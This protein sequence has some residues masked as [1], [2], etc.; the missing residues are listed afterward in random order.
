[1]HTSPSAPL[2]WSLRGLSEVAPPPPPAAQN[3]V[4]SGDRRSTTT[5]PTTLLCMRSVHFNHAM[6]REKHTKS[7]RCLVAAPRRVAESLK[8]QKIR[9]S[10]SGARAPRTPPHD[11]RPT[12]RRVRRIWRHSAEPLFRVSLSWPRGRSRAAE[13]SKISRGFPTSAAR[14]KRTTRCREAVSST[15]VRPASSPQ[16]SQPRPCLLV[17]WPI[18]RGAP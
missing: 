7:R 5:A 2:R 3:E 14:R 18:H 12:E 16:L 6:A 4:C 9:Y 8:S 15:N 17:T 13:I 1:M 10:K 11:S